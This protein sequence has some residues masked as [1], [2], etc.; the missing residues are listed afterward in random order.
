VAGGRQAPPAAAAAAAGRQDSWV[1]GGG[2]GATVRMHWIV[3]KH[4][5]HAA[6][7]HAKIVAG[8]LVQLEKKT[9]VAHLEK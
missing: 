4:L 8:L 1:Q 6:L 7:D 2:V 9:G 5:A 3:N